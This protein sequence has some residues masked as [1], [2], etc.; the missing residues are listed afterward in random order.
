MN[1]YNLKIDLA[2]GKLY[3]KKLIKTNVD[4]TFEK[5]HNFYGL[6]SCLESFLFSH[7][8]TCIFS[9]V[10]TMEIELGEQFFENSVKN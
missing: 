4:F 1:I 10:I 2:G 5:S 3:V 8:G 9:N 7:S 6:I